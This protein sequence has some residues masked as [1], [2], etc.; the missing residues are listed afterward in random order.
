MRERPKSEMGQGRTE[1]QVGKSAKEWHFTL[2]KESVARDVLSLK[3][4]IR[5]NRDLKYMGM[6]VHKAA[7]VMPC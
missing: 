3:E 7:T 5:M 2:R 1:E 6:D 4:A